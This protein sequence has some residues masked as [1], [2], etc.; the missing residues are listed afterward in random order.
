[1]QPVS[2]LAVPS[3]VR[4]S[5]LCCFA[6]RHSPSLGSRSL[7]AEAPLAHLRGHPLVEDPPAWL[8]F[9][10]AFYRSPRGTAGSAENIPHVASLEESGYMDRCAPSSRS[11]EVMKGQNSCSQSRLEVM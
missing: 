6:R 10:Y 7:V 11:S 5:K 4:V 8:R 9:V 2:V 3:V 1:M